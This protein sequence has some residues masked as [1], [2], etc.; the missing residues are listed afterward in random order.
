VKTDLTE[1]INRLTQ[2]KIDLQQ[3]V[4]Q[5]RIELT[6]AQKEKDKI[7]QQLQTTL[8]QLHAKLDERVFEILTAIILKKSSIFI[9]RKFVLNDY[10]LV[11][12][13]VLLSYVKLMNISNKIFI[14]IN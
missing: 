9:R 6:T 14:V 2:D 11:F 5:T 10:H 1:Q 12:I 13:V 8:A 4:N 7:V 3:V